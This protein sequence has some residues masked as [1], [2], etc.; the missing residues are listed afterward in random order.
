MLILL[1]GGLGLAISRGVLRQVGG[2]P[3]EAI[4][5]MSRAAEGD[6]TVSVQSAPA[7]S[8]LASMGH[9]VGS[10]RAMVTEIGHSSDN[11]TRAPSI[12]TASR[13]VA[14]ASEAV[15][16][17]RVDGGGDREMTVASTTSFRQRA[18]Q[19]NSIAR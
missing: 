4:R 5:L 11:L 17:H 18:K 9:M 16:R 6:L 7:G 1:I 15:G 10:I 13:E 8:M 14:T 19:E 2:E 3:S 12:S